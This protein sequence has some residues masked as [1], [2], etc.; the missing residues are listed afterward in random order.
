VVT[1][2]NGTPLD[3]SNDF[4]PTF[5]G[6]DS[7]GNGVLDPGEIWIYTA[8]GT[9]GS[10]QYGN[11]GKVTG[12]DPLGSHLTD[13][14]FSHYFGTKPEIEIIKSG[15][16]DKTVVLPNDRADVGDVI[17][18]TFTVTNTGN[19]PLTSVTVTDPKVTVSGGPITL[20][21]GASDSTTFTATYTLTQADI[22]VG[23]VDNTA[24][25][26]GKDPEQEDVSDDDDETVTIS[27]DPAILVEKVASYDEPLTVGSVITYTYTVTNT[28]NV[29]L[30]G[31]T[32]ID[33]PLGAVTL[34]TTTLAPLAS[35]TGTLTHTITQAD[36]NTGK[37]NNDVVA[38]G[39]PPS[40]DDVTD[41]DDETVTISQG[42][43]LSII[44]TGP[45]TVFIGET[46]TYGITVTNT[47]NVILHNVLFN[48]A[49]LGIV[50]QALGDIVVG[51]SVTIHPTYGPVT[52]N[53]LPG[54]IVNTAI[55]DSD[56]AGPVDDSH[57]VD[58]VTNPGI[59]IEKATNGE[60]A[61][62]SPGPT[63]AV[64]GTVTWTYIVTNTGNVA[65]ANIVVTDSVL[66]AIGTIT[67]LAPGASQTLTKTG[68]AVAGQY[69]NTGTATVTF[70]DTTYTDS[71]DSHYFGAGADLSLIKSVDNADPN[72]GDTIVYTITLT[73]GGPSDATGVQ[74]TD[75][76]PAGLTYASD[77]GAG[78]YSS[79]TNVWTVSSLTNGA[80]VTVAITATVDAGT[81]GTMIANTAE[82]TAAGQPDPDST[83]NNHDPNEDDQS[84]VSITVQS[85]DLVVDKT[86]DNP[87]PN[88]GDTIVYTI[89]ITNDGPSDA[90][91]VTLTD[92]LPVGVT[93]VSDNSGGAYDG[94]M[95]VWTVGSIAVGDIAVLEITATVDAGTAGTTITNTAEV[96]TSDQ[97]DPD[98]TN[99]RDSAD[100]TVTEEPAGGGGATEDRCEGR[101]IINEVAWAGT[102][103]D[104]RDEW[105]ELRNLGTIP[106]DLTGWTLSWR[107][108]QPTTEEEYRWKV[109]DLSGIL[110]PASTSACELADNDSTPF[111][112]FIK[113]DTDDLS[114]WILGKHEDKDES[115]YTI[116][117]RHD[118]T[119]SNEEADLLYD[120]T[121]PYE[122][123]L[124]DLGDVIQLRN[125]LGEVVDTANASH[126]ERDGWPAGSAATF[127]TM[128]RTDP[129]GP[130]AWENWHTNLGI[131]TRGLDAQEQ[132]L[133]ATADTLNSK[134]LE[135]LALN[136]ELPPTKTRAGARLEVGLD[137]P[138]EDRIALGWP[139]IRVTRP[140]LAE[141]AGGGGAVEAG[142]GFS[143]SGRYSH[144]L[145]WLGIDT[146]GLLPGQYNIWIVYGEG[147]AVLV[148]IIVLP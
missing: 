64:G 18:Y 59:A 115:Y 133:I 25:A 65:L 92:L 125:D 36:I 93:Y 102:A 138:R 21:P 50:D 96:T 27:Q 7:N 16:L 103:A 81:A 141:A 67:S 66:G 48:D 73:N 77:N 88:E 145:Y 101:V 30:T 26:T 72:E 70:G 84:S 116:E 76:L 6:G 113:R 31:I 11:V 46:I 111:V 134:E 121:E 13:S 117:R 87:T 139:W 47:G 131:I 54:P 80:S 62:A 108:K 22:N 123:E 129:L 29:T 132:P 89:I 71:D 79:A 98:D 104:S 126:P 140:D 51:S 45:A 32:A 74:V 40:G 34:A 94:A 95:G 52:E 9:V 109:V 49:K 148:P 1:D 19:V 90:T 23:K 118:E 142:A 124:T 143:F 119:I 120:I 24:T 147:K 57:S 105:I 3:P 14:D 38:T 122:M 86:V 144:D 37:V 130:D 97:P 82:V 15:T 43:E 91:G 78:A 114:W 146:S 85:A 12:E 20:A 107:R 136:A 75:A 128:E 28:G 42:P 61:D 58:I 110:L 44:K 99:N 83:P 127:A 10:G 69:A 33:D 106:V 17:E 63:I 35:T 100:I 39:T 68:T 41:D 55:A 112:E 135:E 4:N 8:S 56:E 137:L 53:D 5:I 60:D 2:D